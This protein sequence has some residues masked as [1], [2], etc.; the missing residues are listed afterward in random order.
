MLEDLG[1]YDKVTGGAMCKSCW[2]VPGKTWLTSRHHRET[3][4]R[5][6]VGEADVGIVWTTEVVHAKAEGRT[7]DGVAIPAPLNKQDKVGY[8]IGKL[9]TGRNQDNADTYLAYLA[10]GDAQT[11]YAKYGFIPASAEELQL[12]PLSAKG[13]DVPS[14]GLDPYS[15]PSKLSA[16]PTRYSGA[17][18]PRLGKHSLFAPSSVPCRSG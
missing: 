7:V 8:A 16:R 5:I 9:N 14:E 12:T 6:E 4:D 3:P 11:I 17:G 18:A 10:T 15:R 1:L 13:G 2:A